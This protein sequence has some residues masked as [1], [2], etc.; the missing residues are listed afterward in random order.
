MD[1]GTLQNGGDHYELER[2]RS[3][4]IIDRTPTTTLPFLVTLSNN[5]YLQEKSL[6][7]SNFSYNNSKV[8]RRN[9]LRNQIFTG[10]HGSHHAEDDDE[11]NG[12]EKREREEVEIDKYQQLRTNP[13]HSSRSPA[14]LETYPLRE[15]K[16]ESWDMME[17]VKP[18]RNGNGNG[19]TASLS[20]SLLKHLPIFVTQ[21]TNEIRIELSV[22]PFQP[23]NLSS[24]STDGLCTS[25]RG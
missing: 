7:P 5:E 1:K 16:L 12:I 8:R 11:R 6:K 14:S 20:I 25:L 17:N 22:K 13:L 24:Q 19:E 3:T 4:L 21:I 23:S 2:R 9:I 15:G 18:R 10:E